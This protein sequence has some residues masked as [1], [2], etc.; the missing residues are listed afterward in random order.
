MYGIKIEFTGNSQ[1]EY[2]L[3]FQKYIDK[4]SNGEYNTAVSMLYSELRRFGGM[5]NPY[6]AYRSGVETLHF[7][8]EDQFNQFVEKWSNYEHD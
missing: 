6:Y 5:L 7:M 1:P 4:V 8:T 3:K 2:W